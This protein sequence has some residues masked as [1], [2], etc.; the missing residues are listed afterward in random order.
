MDIVV[1]VVARDRPGLLQRITTVISRL[2]AN[3]IT[4]FGYT[5][6]GRA[7]ILFLAEITHD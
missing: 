1:L 5:V 3:I 4:N 6:D 7:Y 2:G